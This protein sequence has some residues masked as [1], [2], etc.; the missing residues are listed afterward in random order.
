M[1][2]LSANDCRDGYKEYPVFIEWNESNTIADLFAKLS[3]T[4]KCSKEKITAIIAYCGQIC[5]STPNE[6]LE[7]QMLR[8]HPSTLGKILDAYKFTPIKGSFMS[9]GKSCGS[10]TVHKS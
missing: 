7:E 4:L 10:V 9:Q 6:K 8:Q 2:K 5:G 3:E 1:I